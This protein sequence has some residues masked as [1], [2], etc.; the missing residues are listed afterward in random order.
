MGGQAIGVPRGIRLKA[1]K[2]QSCRWLQ[3]RDTWSCVGMTTP[4][5]LSL[6]LAS[7]P[8]VGSVAYVDSS[9]TWGQ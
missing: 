4:L 1:G 9:L 7:V 2:A 6:I 3:G 5:A 8:Y